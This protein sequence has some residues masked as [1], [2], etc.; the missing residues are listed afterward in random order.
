MT[1]TIRAEIRHQLRAEI[2]PRLRNLLLTSITSHQEKSRIPV[3]YQPLLAQ[4]EKAVEA[5]AGVRVG[6]GAKAGARVED[7]GAG[8]ETAV[9]VAVGAAEAKAV[10]AEVAGVRTVE[11]AAKVKVAEK[12]RAVESRPI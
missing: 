8:A 2:Q 7:A 9:A 1:E 11:A 3:S 5:G 12:A 6:V 10:A 4:V